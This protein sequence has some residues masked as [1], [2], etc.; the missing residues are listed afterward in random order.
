MKKKRIHL[1]PFQSIRPDSDSY[2]P[3]SKSL[4]DYKGYRDLSGSAKN[5]YNQC[6]IQRYNAVSRKRP[7]PDKFPADRYPDYD[8]VTSD[9]FYMNLAL[10]KALGLYK[11]SNKKKFYSDLHRLEES[12]LID[13]IIKASQKGNPRRIKNVYRMSERWKKFFLQGVK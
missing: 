8:M 3:I 4:Q 13:A 10:V 5:L 1:L 11:E 9:C 2:V 7:D 12:G 6:V